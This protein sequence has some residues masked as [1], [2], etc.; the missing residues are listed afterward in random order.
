MRRRRHR[1][2]TAGD[3]PWSVAGMFDDPDGPTDV[4][5]NKHAYLSEAYLPQAE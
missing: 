3:S 5:S 4:S 2:L 1:G